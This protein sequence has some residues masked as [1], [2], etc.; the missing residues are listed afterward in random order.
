MHGDAKMVFLARS[1]RNSG[2]GSST[3]DSVTSRDLPCVET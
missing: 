1:K 2:E 3:A